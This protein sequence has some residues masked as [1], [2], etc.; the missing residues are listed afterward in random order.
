MATFKIVMIYI[1]TI[2]ICYL[3]GAIPNGLILGKVFKH[4]DIREQG[5]HSTGGT[6]AGRILGAKFGVITI[7][8]DALKIV[9]PF[10]L[11][12]LILGNIN[13]FENHATN[14]QYIALMIACLAH[15]YS[16]YIG[17]KGGKAVA[18]FLGCLFATNYILLIAFVV[19][20][21]IVLLISKY[22]SLSSMISSLCT[23]LLAFILFMTSSTHSIFGTWP[24]LESSILLVI[25]ITFNSLLLIVRHK[26]NIKRLINKTESKVKWLK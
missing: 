23:A 12:K 22:V 11:M 15:C 1:A 2:L 7:V 26:E 18:T 5:S 6:N 13:G 20:F 17:F 14:L 8:L 10:W 4:V 24:G 16:V 9:I 25:A 3:I 21:A 19:I